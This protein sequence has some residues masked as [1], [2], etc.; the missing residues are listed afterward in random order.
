MLSDRPPW[1]RENEELREEMG[2]PR[3]E[4]SRLADG[5]YVHEISEELEDEHDCTIQLVSDDPSYPSRWTVQVDGVGCAD[6]G[7]RRDENRNTIYEISADELRRRV[8][9]TLER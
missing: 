9:E 5:T 3:Y 4:P 6:V 8:E 7:R 1:W 2:L